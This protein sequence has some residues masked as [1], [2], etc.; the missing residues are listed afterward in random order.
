MDDFLLRNGWSVGINTNTMN[1]NVISTSVTIANEDDEGRGIEME[2]NVERDGNEETDE[3]MDDAEAGAEDVGMDDGEE[4]EEMIHD[5]GENEN[6]DLEEPGSDGKS[7]D[8]GQLVQEARNMRI[9]RHLT[10]LGADRAIK[11]KRAL[12]QATRALYFA[13]GRYLEISL[14]PHGKKLELHNI[15]VN[16]ASIVFMVKHLTHRRHSQITRDPVM[17]KKICSAIP[18]EIKNRLH[19]SVLG[20]DV[21]EA[22]WKDMK[23]TLL[24]SWISPVPHDWGTTKRGKLSADNWRVVCTIH[25]PVTLIWLWKDETGR[26]RELLENF[27]DLVTA[28]R[29]ANMRLSSSDQADA[30]DKHILRYV[31]ALPSLFPHKSLRPNHHAALHIGDGLRWFGPVHAHSASHYERHISF[32]HRININNKVGEYTHPFSQWISLFMNDE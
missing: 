4:E 20:K 23:K 27:M 1:S 5:G 18:E 15:V 26:K 13:I 30:Y 16:L 7:K 17:H 29:L 10:D 11:Q 8:L 6:E 31:Q 14:P 25:L 19:S 21:M 28:V 2:E 3:E 12:A 24:P 32:L 9:L 22:V